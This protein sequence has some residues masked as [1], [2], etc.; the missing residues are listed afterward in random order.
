MRRATEEETAGTAVI[1][2]G[3]VGAAVARALA[4]RGEPVTIIEAERPGHSLASS[5]GDARIRVL[6]AYP[7]DEYLQLGLVADRLWHELE[8]ETTR[9]ILHPTGAL[10]Y[11]RLAERLARA[12]GEHRVD[13]Q[14]MAPERAAAIAPAVRLPDHVDQVLWQPDGAIIAAETGLA[15]MIE[16]AL[17]HGARLRRGEPVSQVEPDADR[18][19]LHLDGAELRFERAIVVA[20]AWTA[21]LL[22]WPELGAL[23]PTAQT[24]SHFRREGEPVPAVIDYDGAEPYAGW[25]PGFGLKTADHEFGPTVEP[26]HL[27]A[28]DPERIA[29]SVEWVAERFGL[30]DGPAM[31]ETCVY[32][33]TPDERILI[34]RKGPITAVSACNGQGFQ[35]APA[36]GETV[37]GRV[38]ED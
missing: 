11:G 29:A 34:E 21:S 26:G 25:T 10:S 27:P 20:G 9:R 13:H 35:L 17:A 8:R 14:L 23:R 33:N 31:T 16:S 19:V 28:P 12:L 3:I 4:R 1:G 7:D 22:G 15:A 5:K 2:A 6:A 18:V 38:L 36:V 24:V 37:A 32:T 30:S